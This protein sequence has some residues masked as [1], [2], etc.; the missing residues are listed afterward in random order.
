[1]S[2]VAAA[3]IIAGGTIG[4]SL[5][6]KGKKAK[7]KE[8]K[9]MG[10]ARRYLRDLMN[11]GTPALPTREI[12]EMTP[13]E[14]RGQTILGEYADQRLP[15]TFTTGQSELLKTARGGYSDLTQSPFFQP[16][17]NTIN[18]TS[19]EQMQNLLRRLQLGGMGLSTP[20]G[21]QVAQGVAQGSEAVMTALAPYADAE[22]QRQFGAIPQL[23]QY[24]DYE[25]DQPLNILNAIAAYG[26]LP[27]QIQQ[28]QYNAAYQ[29]LYEE[30][31]FPYTTGADLARGILGTG[32]GQVTQPE[33]STASQ[34][35]PMLST[36]MMLMAM[37]GGG[38]SPGQVSSGGMTYTPASAA[39]PP[40][41]VQNTGPQ[42]ANQWLLGY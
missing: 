29:P 11:Q 32:V 19:N 6:G 8:P 20:G 3:G 13:L 1:M 27:R 26:G 9:E 23:L 30:T 14:E 12:A 41:F 33:P 17:I 38:G 35:A 24:A 22:R 18:R 16:I 10:E 36:L 42:L 37:G 31:M 5:L 28:E 21:K 25:M 40:G 15:E 39:V 7:Y 4:A 34:I 2:F